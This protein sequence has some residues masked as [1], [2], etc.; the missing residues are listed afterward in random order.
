MDSAIFYGLHF[1]S[2][3]SILGQSWKQIKSTLWYQTRNNESSDDSDDDEQ[4]YIPE[5]LSLFHVC[6]LI[7][8]LKQPSKVDSIVITIR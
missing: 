6:Y 7:C 2:K 1:S 5:V 4:Y 8:F 3:M